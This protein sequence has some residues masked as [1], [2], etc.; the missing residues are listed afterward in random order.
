MDDETPRLQRVGNAS[1]GSKSNQR[2]TDSEANCEGGNSRKRRVFPQYLK[3][4]SSQ[5]EGLE[6]SLPPLQRTQ[7]EAFLTG[8]DVVLPVAVERTHTGGEPGGK[9]R[10]GIKGLR[11]GNELK[12]RA[13]SPSHVTGD[14]DAALLYL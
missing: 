9:T 11:R 7:D 5:G 14:A 3:G 6:V 10:S 4:D 13:N 1:Q 2:T 8:A 12:A